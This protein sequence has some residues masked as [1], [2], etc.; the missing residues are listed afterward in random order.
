MNNLRPP[1]SPILRRRR[2]PTFLGPLVIPDLRQV[3][4]L[5]HAVAA[6]VVI[7]EAS[8]LVHGPQTHLGALAAVREPGDLME[9]EDAEAGET[10]G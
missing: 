3:G 6:S 4:L 1:P 10:L 2:H 5:R 7:F 9:S 8:D